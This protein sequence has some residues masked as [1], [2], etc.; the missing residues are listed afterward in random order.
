MIEEATNPMD[1]ESKR[2]KRAARTLK[3]PR[4]C[5]RFPEFLKEATAEGGE[6]IGQ[7]R[8]ARGAVFQ[9]AWGGGREI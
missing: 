7:P 5:D 9:P 3:D 4:L 6:D 2:M 1:L 8:K